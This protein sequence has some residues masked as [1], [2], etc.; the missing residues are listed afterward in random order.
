MIIMKLIKKKE[1]KKKKRK[2]TKERR[3]K[4]KKKTKTKRRFILIKIERIPVSITARN[5]Q[6]EVSDKIVQSIMIFLF[7]L[8]VPVVENHCFMYDDGL[9]IYCEVLGK[10][11]WT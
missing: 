2:K 1:S 7:L 9:D 3:G 11:F 5:E 6:G 4:N 8:Y 10:R